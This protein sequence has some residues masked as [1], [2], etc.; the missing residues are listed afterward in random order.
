MITCP[1]CNYVRRPA[2]VSPEYEC[3]K[4]GVIYAKFDAPRDMPITI[5]HAKFSSNWMDVQL[6]VQPEEHAEVAKNRN[7]AVENGETSSVFAWLRKALKITTWIVAIFVAI[8]LFGIAS[9]YI[10]KRDIKKAQTEEFF[11]RN[12]MTPEARIA[13]DAARAKAEAEKIAAANKKRIYDLGMAACLAKWKSGLK[14][15]DSGLVVELQGSVDDN[16]D[17]YAWIAGRAKNS[18][19]AVVPRRTSCKFTLVNGQASV[20]LF[21]N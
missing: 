3:P 12:A 15:P 9:R 16:G 2:D 13:E 4:C 1:K 7:L 5:A 6:S 8:A 21:D 17:F 11:R 20:E 10:E 19:G 18:F 14:D